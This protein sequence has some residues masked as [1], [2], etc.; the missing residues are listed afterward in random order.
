MMV[1]AQAT[2]TAPDRV[3]QLNDAVAVPDGS[4]NNKKAR[5]VNSK[6]VIST[7]L[8]F[9]VDLVNAD[10]PACSDFD[11]YITKGHAEIL[12]D[13]QSFDFNHHTPLHRHQ[14]GSPNR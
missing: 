5:I 1:T 14:P 7:Q 9:V 6:Q 2:E 8:V 10:F 3:Q 11:Q 4:Q 13:T 12:H